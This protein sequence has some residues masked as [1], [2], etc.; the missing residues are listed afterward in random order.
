MHT[1]STL[2]EQLGLPSQE[3]DIESFI[4]E[5]KLQNNNIHLAKADFWSPAQQ[6]FLEESLIED[7]VWSEVVDQLDVLLRS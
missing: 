6:G 1:M 3:A 4:A 7:S 2:F 5:H